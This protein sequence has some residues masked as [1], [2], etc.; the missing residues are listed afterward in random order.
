MNLHDYN[1]ALFQNM[2]FFM[3]IVW[4]INMLT[5]T[6]VILQ[7][8]SEPEKDGVEFSYHDTFCD[9]TANKVSRDELPVF[10][11]Y[12]DFENMKTLKQ[13]TS[14]DVHLSQKDGSRDLYRIVLTPAFEGDMLSCVYLGAR[15]MQPEIRQ[16][17]AVRE[18]YEAAERANA[19]KSE[20]LNKISH[21]I[22][23]PM[24]AI[25]GM[26]AIA[27]KHQDNQERV[28][29]CLKK[30]S[31]SSK[32]LLALVDEMLDMSMIE[33]GKLKLQEEEIHL[34]ELLEN[35]EILLEIG[36]KEKGHE[37]SL[38]VLCLE[39]EKVWGDRRRIDQIFMNVI[40]NA[41]KYTMENG[42][43]QVT[44]EEKPTSTQG[45]GCYE[46]VVEDNGI[47]ME[48][49]FLEH[50]FEPFV[51]AKDKRVERIQGSGLGLAIMSNVVRMMNGV[52]DV[53]STPGKGTRVAVRIFLKLLEE[54]EVVFPQL[55][56]A[57]ALVVNRDEALCREV[58][59]VMAGLGVQCEWARTE[60]GA[61]KRIE[62]RHREN[63]DYRTVIIDRGI[64]GKAEFIDLI[65][66]MNRIAD[67]LTAIAVWSDSDWTDME[68]DARAAGA[69]AFIA[70]ACSR[71][72]LIQLFKMLTGQKEE[73]DQKSP[74][75][76]LAERNFHGRRA[77]MVEDNESNADII[78]EILQIAGL[79]VE[80]AWNGQE[81]VKKMLT[82]K[83]WYYDIV[84][85]DIQMPVMDGYEAVKTIR[86]LERE[87][88]QEVP[89]LAMSAN[90]FEEDVQ[91]SLEAG[92]NEHIS[93]PIDFRKLEDAL[94]RWL[95]TE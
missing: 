85:M 13:E 63:M 45:I 90:A 29:E 71:L 87:Y 66:R 18:A 68:E 70:N 58:C 64:A 41:V 82:A 44:L 3:D 36:M 16:Q 24:N 30:I 34:P 9:Y 60:K 5:G 10:E 65:A 56:D 95:P 20:F 35:L 15:N 4:E 74:L 61:L 12:M 47:G 31:L 69:V 23:T 48:P 46:I 73:A 94:C 32:Y 80:Q 25:I 83:D 86:G 1:H 91:A 39:H 93:K 76:A 51:R 37:F 72:R 53:K 26:T 55:A 7:D 11:G 54:E 75:E 33:S 14:F 8:S 2:A 89:I 38:E 57:V 77:L 52:I 21:D 81:A 84:F 43:I 19:A 88:A 59:E 62:E 6:V 42:R 40:D 92:M 50:M 28:A 49:E 27:E 67:G 17:E 79:E 22:R 78:C